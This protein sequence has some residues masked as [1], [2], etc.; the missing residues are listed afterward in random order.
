MSEERKKIKQCPKCKANSFMIQINEYLDG[1]EDITFIC[2]G[3]NTLFENQNDIPEKEIIIIS[4]V[5]QNGIRKIIEYEYKSKVKI[6]HGK[7]IENK[8]TDLL[9]EIA[10]TIPTIL[11]WNDFLSFRKQFIEDY[12]K[13]LDKLQSET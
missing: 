10:Y 6:L 1:G 2:L 3:C 9:D 13:I 12:K 4:N 11:N 7:E 5:S 8:K